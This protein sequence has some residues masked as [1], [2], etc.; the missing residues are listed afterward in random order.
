M[1]FTLCVAMTVRVWCL[2]IAFSILVAT[3]ELAMQVAA[4][5]PLTP[6][7]TIRVVAP[8][9][10]PGT[11]TAT[12][13]AADHDTLVLKVEGE[14]AGLLVPLDGVTRVQIY[15][16]RRSDPAAAAGG[17]I[18]GLAIGAGAGWLVGPSLCDPNDDSGQTF[19]SSTTTRE[20]TR[21]AVVF[22]VIGALTGGMIAGDRRERWETIVLERVRVSPGPSGGVA[23]S[24]SLSH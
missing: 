8:A 2:W 16:G 3:P 22:G 1:S 15:R 13:L 21:G 17:A 7:A 19:C 18:L 24:V 9:V 20:R 11:L 4:A 6:G 10:A 5:S 12:V 14:A 23:V